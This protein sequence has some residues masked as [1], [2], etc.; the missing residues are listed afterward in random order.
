MTASTFAPALALVTVLT[1]AL[2]AVP[3]CA[4]T[5]DAEEGMHVEPGLWKTRTELTM[6]MLPQPRVQTQEQCLRRSE[7]DAETFARE[8]EGDCRITDREL[9][10]D[11]MRWRM[12]CTSDGQTT[13]GEGRMRS[14]GDTVEGELVLTSRVGGREFTVESTWTSERVGPCP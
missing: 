14:S 5:A 7:L 4:A 2:A 9:A 11:R 3:S 6:P 8:P 10:P 12:E 1:A 13:V